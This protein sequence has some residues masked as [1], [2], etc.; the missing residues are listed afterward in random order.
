MDLP[1]LSDFVL[2]GAGPALYLHIPFCSRKCSYCDFFSIPYSDEICAE[3]IPGILSQIDTF[4]K[5]L[6]PDSYDTLYIGGGTPNILSPGNFEALLK[7]ILPYVSKSLPPEWTV[8]LNPEHIDAEYLEI[9]SAFPVTRISLGIQSFHDHLLERIGRNSSREINRRALET[10]RTSWSGDVSTDILCGIP[11]QR[12]E[13][14]DADIDIL[15]EYA[16]DHVSLYT[17]TVEEGTPLASMAERGIVVPLEEERQLLLWK[18]AMEGLKDAG[19]ERY[20]ISNFSL[21]GK[22]CRHNIH[23]WEMDPYIGCGPG[24]VSTLRGG[25]ELLR[26]ETERR[27]VR[28]PRLH[29]ER[30]DR[31]SFM[32]E[33]LMMGFRM[34]RGIRK[35]KFQTI[36]SGSFNSLF[37]EE[38]NRFKE[39]ELMGEDENTV[40]MTDRGLEILN[41]VLLEFAVHI[42]ILL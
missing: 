18:R 39:D 11:G 23:Y 27:A 35:S 19:Y 14:I 13:E 8:E 41:R 32:L 30:I 25:S 22:E 26:I 1:D 31:K 16:P 24:A 5:A 40:Y 3:V 36:F 2:P 6:L 29:F 37:R 9:L 15:G 4:H 21:P 34:L 10:I 7:G 33:Y 20:E 42:D 12:E 17:L 28:T 38:L